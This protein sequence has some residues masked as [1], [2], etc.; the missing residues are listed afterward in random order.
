[1]ENTGICANLM[2]KWLEDIL[3][4]GDAKRVCDVDISKGGIEQ[5]TKYITLNNVNVSDKAIRVCFW[6]Q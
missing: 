3:K 6:S 2:T 1:M 5:L 4:L